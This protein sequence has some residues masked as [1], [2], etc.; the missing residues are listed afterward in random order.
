MKHG[1]RL[2]GAALIAVGAVWIVAGAVPFGGA[3]KTVQPLWI[4]AGAFSL[5]SGAATLLLLQFRIRRVLRRK[6]AP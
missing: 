5:G 2:L 3:S 1:F 6:P 4:I